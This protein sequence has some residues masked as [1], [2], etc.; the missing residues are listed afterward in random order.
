M[1][2]KNTPRAHFIQFSTNQMH[3]NA[4]ALLP[5]PN[6]G[7]FNLMVVGFS[8]ASRRRG[9]HPFS[10]VLTEARLGSQARPVTDELRRHCNVSPEAPKLHV[11]LEPEFLDSKRKYFDTFIK[12][13]KH[14]T[15]P[16]KAN[17]L[18]QML[19]AAACVVEALSWERWPTL[20]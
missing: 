3:L 16:S 14:F 15:A 9:N 10:P 2:Q 17:A 18:S 5:P 7:T 1:E 8:Q 19:A 12:K 11:R 6:T 20:G 13:N 4:P